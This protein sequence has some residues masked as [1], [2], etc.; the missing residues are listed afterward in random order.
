MKDKTEQNEQQEQNIKGQIE[1]RATDKQVSLLNE[2]LTTAVD[3]GGH[4]LNA[5]GKLY[6]KLYP[7]GFAVSPFNAV[8]LALDSDAKGCKTN[9]FTLFSEA[10]ARGGE[11]EGA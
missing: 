11:C 7:K 10:K 2:A 8:I 6:P 1:K 9:L 4:W 3:A 5:S